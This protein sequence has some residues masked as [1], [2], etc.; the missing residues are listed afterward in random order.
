MGGAQYQFLLDSGCGMTL[1]PASM[2]HSNNVANKSWTATSVEGKN[3]ELKGE[4]TVELKLGNLSFTTRALVSENISEP[5]IGFDWLVQ[6]NV[7]WG[8]GNNQI[9]IKGQTFQITQKMG[10]YQRGS[11]I[12]KPAPVGVEESNYNLTDLFNEDLLDVRNNNADEHFQNKMMERIQKLEQMP[13]HI[14]KQQNQKRNAKANRSQK[15]IKTSYAN[16]HNLNSSSHN[17]QPS[18][19]SQRRFHRTP[20]P[21]YTPRDYNNLTCFTCKSLHHISRNCPSRPRFPTGVCYYCGSETHLRDKC[22]HFQINRQVNSKYQVSRL[23]TTHD[24]D[25][26]DKELARSLIHDVTNNFPRDEA[27]SLPPMLEIEIETADDRPE[28]DN[29]QRKF[30]LE[31]RPRR[32]RKTPLYLEDY[33][34]E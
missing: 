5:I 18:A 6:N 31:S 14:H 27:I 30:P 9:L 19:R 32:E 2:I 1:L 16:Y 21:V 22:S 13:K 28:K 24:T 25:V 17:G 7:Y 34:C 10:G 20:C 4:V 29:T 12:K 26:V 23:T 15:K 8:F 3:V 33:S 11:H